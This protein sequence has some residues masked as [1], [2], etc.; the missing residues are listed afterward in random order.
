MTS[1]LIKKKIAL[2]QTSLILKLIFIISAYSFINKKIILY[3]LKKRDI[4]INLLLHG[5]MI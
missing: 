1:F 4:N 3:V 2:W 5:R